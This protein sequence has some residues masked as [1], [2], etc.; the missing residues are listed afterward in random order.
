MSQEQE[1][2]EIETTDH[3]VTANGAEVPQSSVG[4]GLPPVPFSPSPELSTQQAATALP[5]SAATQTAATTAKAKSLAAPV[6]P[7]PTMEQLEQRIVDRLL[8]QLEVFGYYASSPNGID[9]TTTTN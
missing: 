8:T 4:D 7:A 3:T 2:P 5:Q 9:R 1:V 6:G